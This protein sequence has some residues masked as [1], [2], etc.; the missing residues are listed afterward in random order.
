MHSKFKIHFCWIPSHV[1]I[2]RNEIVDAAAKESSCD[3]NLDIILNR[4]PHLD[5]KRP[6]KDYILKKWQGRWASPG[7]KNNKKYRNIR[8]SVAFW[9]SSYQNNRRNE[10]ILSRLRIGHSRV[11]HSF[12]FDGS[13]PPECEHC[14]VPLT[15]E[16]ILVNCILYEDKRR[17]YQLHRKSI[18]SILGDELDVE[19][20]MSFLKD[21]ELYFKL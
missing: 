1:G 3:P 7:L 13:D 16:H 18:G 5:M 15:I 8:P 17:F 2:I 12:L 21:I 19:N 6:I 20:L 14:M 4:I 10:K 11:T 9:S